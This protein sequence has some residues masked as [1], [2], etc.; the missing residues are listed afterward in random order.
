MQDG[1][2]NQIE[3][4]ER[5]D[6]LQHQQEAWQTLQWK[7]YIFP[8][9]TRSVDISGSI[10]AETIVNR[11]RSIK[12]TRAL[13]SRRHINNSGS[14]E[15]SLDD[16]GIVLDTWVIDPSQDLLVATEILQEFVTSEC[17]CWSK[18]TFQIEH[19]TINSYFCLATYI[20]GLYLLV[21]L[22]PKSLVIRQ[23]YP[24]DGK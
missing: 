4:A 1:L 21:I 14:R 5:L 3:S 7:A 22:T 17:L 6:M 24:M 18:L 23:L 2:P 19:L 11:D 20:S 12:L 15:W 10:L 13:S 8:A 16:L 9:S